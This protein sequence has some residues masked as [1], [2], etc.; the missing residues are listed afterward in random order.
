MFNIGDKAWLKSSG[1]VIEVIGF[2]PNG[3]VWCQWESAAGLIEE[4]S[5]L[6]E[7]LCLDRPAAT[8]NL[9]DNQSRRDLSEWVKLHLD[10]SSE[11]F[12]RLCEQAP[13]RPAG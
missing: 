3:R 12:R 9:D 8:D 1:P 4:A 7:M 2:S 6:P 13:V 5:F 10:G 11:D